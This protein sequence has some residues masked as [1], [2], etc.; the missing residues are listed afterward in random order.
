MRFFVAGSMHFAK[1][2][3]EVQKILHGLG[4]KAVVSDDTDECVENPGLN[5][6]SEHNF[7]K[8]LMRSCM[9]IMDKSDAILVLN[10]PKEGV[11]GYIGAHSLIEMGLAYYLRQK[12]FLLHPPPPKE[13]ARYNQEVMH[14]KPIVLNGDVSK[15]NEHI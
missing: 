10:Y 3:L 4:H 6:D 8:D 5:M 7:E 1:E 14:M 13:K 11:E 15:I 2:M 9:N 12:I